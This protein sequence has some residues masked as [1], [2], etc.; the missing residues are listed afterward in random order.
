MSIPR[1]S[2]RA[3]GDIGP[4]DV[5]RDAIPEIIREQDHTLLIV[6]M[7]ALVCFRVGKSPLRNLCERYRLRSQVLRHLDAFAGLSTA[8]L[9]QLDCSRPGAHFL[10]PSTVL[11]VEVLNPPDTRA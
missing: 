7:A 2:N 8:L 6:A 9:D 5:L 3:K 1:P 4:C 10:A 11:T